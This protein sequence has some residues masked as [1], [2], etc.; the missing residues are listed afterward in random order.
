MIA[1]AFFLIL[2]AVLIVCAAPSPTTRQTPGGRRLLDGYSTKI[3]FARDPDV[4]LWE[5]S[6]KPPGIDGGDPIDTNT[7]HNVSWRT[8]AARALKT[9]T[10]STFTA[11]YDPDCYNQLLQLVNVYDTLTVRFPDGSTLAFY[12]F[13]R[14]FDPNDNTEGEMPTATVTF[15]PTNYDYTNAV[16]AAPVLTSV[17]GT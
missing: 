12:G 7:M 6:V 9:L 5:V 15:Q 10:E 16:E 4:S 1:A 11:A 14:Q 2:M 3:T 13:L 17:A 8:M